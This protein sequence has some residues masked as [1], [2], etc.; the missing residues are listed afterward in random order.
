M[1]G[2]EE[3]PLQDLHSRTSLQNVSVLLGLDY[4]IRRMSPYNNSHITYIISHNFVP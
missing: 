3:M 1:S 2:T 4:N